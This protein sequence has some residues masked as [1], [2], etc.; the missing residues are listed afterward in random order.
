MMRHRLRTTLSGLASAA[1][2]LMVA[3][4]TA[5]ANELRSNG[6]PS[7]LDSGDHGYYIWNDG[8]DLHVRMTGGDGSDVFH[9]TLHTDGKFRDLSHDGDHHDEH[10]AIDDDEH[11]L[12]FRATPGS[13]LDGFKV[14]I[15][16]ADHV[17]LDLRRGDDAI[18]TDRIWVGNDNDHPD[19]NSFTIRV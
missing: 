16:D 15:E 7:N 8:H 12:H 19:D 17:H 1:L 5:S 2:V 3:T 13:D 14:R 10:V 11:T 6:S 9:G 18:P 4:T